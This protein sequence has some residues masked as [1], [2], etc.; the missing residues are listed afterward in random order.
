MEA[1]AH[2]FGRALTGGGEAGEVGRRIGGQ[3]GGGGDEQGGREGGGERSHRGSFAGRA[4]GQ[5]RHA[6]S[7]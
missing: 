3:R 6:A 2:R 7:P 4:G 1:G 5:M